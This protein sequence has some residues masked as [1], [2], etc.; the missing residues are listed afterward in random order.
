MSINTNMKLYELFN[1]VTIENSLGEEIKKIN[2]FKDVLVSVHEKTI[3]LLDANNIYKKEVVL[4][5]LT[6]DNSIKEG[7]VI[8]IDNKFY[9]IKHI[10]L[11]KRINSMQLEETAYD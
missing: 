11:S 9:N 8:K 3:N 6:K 10:A 1:V 2:K 5:G 7:M 4:T